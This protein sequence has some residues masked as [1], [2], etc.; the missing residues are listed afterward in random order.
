MEHISDL[1][2]AYLSGPMTGYADYNRPAFRRA[3][4]ELR[5]RGY[6]VLSPAEDSDETTDWDDCLRKDLIHLTKVTMVVVLPDWERSRGARLEVAVGA[7]LGLPIYTY[8][9]VGGL[10]ARIPDATLRALGLAV[11][12]F[13]GNPAEAPESVLDEARR[14]VHGERR[15]DYDHPLDNH[16][17][18]G[19]LWAVQLEKWVQDEVADALLA[20]GEQIDPAFAQAFMA[21]FKTCRLSPVPA[22]TVANAMIGLKLA[23]EAFTAKR[24]NQVDTIGYAAC[25]DLIEQEQARRADLYGGGG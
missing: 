8:G 5:D 7:A 14:I 10:L 23:R 21:H 4:Y 3:A 25:I 17:R 9:G 6:T 18:I 2:V 12:E 20:M 15:R 22:R 13:P 11:C 24:D 1:D 16:E 19:I